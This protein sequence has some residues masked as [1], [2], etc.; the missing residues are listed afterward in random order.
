MVSSTHPRLLRVPTSLLPAALAGLRHLRLILLPQTKTS[1]ALGDTTRCPETPPKSP[2]R[3]VAALGRLP[4]PAA[5]TAELLTGQ[6]RR[7]SP[8]AAVPGARRVRDRGL[9]QELLQDLGGQR[10]F[11]GQTK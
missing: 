5:G 11:C 2:R 4:S 9:A 6:K 8:G 1:Q 10:S 7:K 3:A